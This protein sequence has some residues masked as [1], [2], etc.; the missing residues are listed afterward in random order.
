MTLLRT[1]LTIPIKTFLQL[2]T[3]L[4][5]EQEILMLGKRQQTTLDRRAEAK[6][7]DMEVNLR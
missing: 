4:K 2:E 6:K 1:Y 5:K 7:V 3:Q